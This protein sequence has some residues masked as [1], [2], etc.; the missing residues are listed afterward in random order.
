[1]VAFR[2]RIIKKESEIAW[3][4]MERCK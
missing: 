2:L 4:L 1:M 3:E